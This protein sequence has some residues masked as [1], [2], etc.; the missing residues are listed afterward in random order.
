MDNEK[1]KVNFDSRFAIRLVFYTLVF[2][3][4]F[5]F[6]A[7]ALISLKMSIVKPT[8]DL[9]YGAKTPPYIHRPPTYRGISLSLVCYMSLVVA[10]LNKNTFILFFRDNWKPFLIYLVSMIAFETVGIVVEITTNSFVSYYASTF[11]LSVGSI[12]LALLFWF[13]LFP[14]LKDFI[15]F[16]K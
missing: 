11:I 8:L 4:L 3:V 14:S 7:D 12:L 16:Q 6:L 1:I 13:F 2:M 10:S 5:Y 15:N 9:L